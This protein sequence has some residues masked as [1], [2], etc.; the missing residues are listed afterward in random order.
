M[1]DPILDDACPSIPYEPAPDGPGRRPTT[2][3]SRRRRVGAT[4]SLTEPAAT[5]SAGNERP[6]RTARPW[7]ALEAHHAAL[8]DVHLRAALRRRPERG[9][10]ALTVEAGRHHARL[11]EEPGHRRDACASCWHWPRTCGLREPHRGD[12]PRRA[13]QR[14]R[15]PRRAARRPPRARGRGASR[16][17][18]TTSCPTCTPCSTGWPASPTA[19]ARG[20]WLG[21]TGKPIRNVVNIGIGGSD[22]GPD[23]AYQALVALQR[24]RS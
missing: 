5:R 18:A 4:P 23:M 8:K 16:S 17:T 2:L 9:A 22:L 11:L 3:V 10:S 7:K 15:G 13:H 1:V 24:P 6:A 12:V 20:A 19:C 21:H 14:H